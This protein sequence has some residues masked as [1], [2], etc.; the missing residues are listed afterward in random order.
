MDSDKLLSALIILVLAA[1]FITALAA[2]LLPSDD[3]RVVK[4]NFKLE[5]TGASDVK[6]VNL[7]IESNATGVLLAFTK[8]SGNVY[9]I[10]TERDEGSV[11]PSVNRTVDGENLN[12][13]VKMDGGAAR[14]LL[15]NEYTYNIT[16][17]SK[18][19]GF[20]AILSNDSRIDTLNSTIE[21]AGGGTLLIGRTA[22]KNISMSVNTGGFYI[23]EMQPD[24]Q[25]NGSIYTD[26]YIGGTTLAMNKLRNLRIMVDVDYG[27]ISFEPRGFN[28]ISN[29]TGHLEME[30]DSYRTA[31]SRVDIRN[32]VG[33]GGFSMIPYMLPFGFQ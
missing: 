16:I 5:K 17:R 21:Y 27:G 19:G 32:M 23:T 7:D 25:G 15:S 33:L 10:E 26:V 6:Y 18:V 22:F 13:N 4:E 28:V 9:N 14:V 31:D 3:D 2:P 12:I 1:A 24:I 29:R 30:G 11:A 20:T 8:N